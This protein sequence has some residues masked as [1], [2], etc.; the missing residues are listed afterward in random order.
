M[1][2]KRS[3]PVEFKPESIPAPAPGGDSGET[4]PRL[5]VQNEET[6]TEG[7]SVPSDASLATDGRS[8]VQG[9][10]SGSGDVLEAPTAA[11]DKFE[12]NENKAHDEF[13]AEVSIAA[14]GDT[15]PTQPNPAPS[16]VMAVSAKPKDGLKRFV[17]Q[18]AMVGVYNPGATV[19]QETLGLDDSR[20]DLFVSQGYLIPV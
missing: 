3:K 13:E 14:K 16:E 11:R 15:A 9:S 7:S 17:I 10:E 5:D 19:D 1:T 2:R 4:P 20:I 12:A 6:L 8:D 18:R